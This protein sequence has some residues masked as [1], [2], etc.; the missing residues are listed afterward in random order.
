MNITRFLPLLVGANKITISLSRVGDKIEAVIIP[1]LAVL[2][3]REANDEVDQLRAFLATPVVFRESAEGFDAGLDALVQEVADIRAPVAQTVNERVAAIRLQAQ[4][5]TQAAANAASA[6]KAKQEAA[7]KAK[8][9]AA[10]TAKRPNS[11]KTGGNGAAVASAK[12]AGSE[13]QEKG[14]GVPSPSPVPK[15][16]Q[17]AV[18]G[19]AP[20]V[21][22]AAPL[23]PAEAVPTNPMLPP[24]IVKAMQDGVRVKA[25]ATD[26]QVSLF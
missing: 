16:I 25:S 2:K 8:R 6:A 5:A 14:D 23:P 15:A 18:R 11:V 26:A 12:D 4:A 10:A 21:D 1:S 24:D 13:A 17:D 9:D 3:D 19:S 7:A 20:R 22:G